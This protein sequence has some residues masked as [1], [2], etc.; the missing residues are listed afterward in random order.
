MACYF[1]YLCWAVVEVLGIELIMVWVLIFSKAFHS[2]G[3]SSKCD[4]FSNP[5]R[6]IENKLCYPCLEFVENS[7]N[8]ANVLG[9][10]CTISESGVVRRKAN[11][12]ELVKR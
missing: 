4:I 12:V 6:W 5:A 8:C 11:L 9:H 10:F 3:E 2:T 7:Q 1:Y